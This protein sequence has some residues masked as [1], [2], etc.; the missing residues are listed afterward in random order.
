M[1]NQLELRCGLM[2]RAFAQT[3]FVTGALFA[4]PRLRNGMRF[5]RRCRFFVADDY[6]WTIA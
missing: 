4:P 3:E 1:P 6:L 2:P 5:P